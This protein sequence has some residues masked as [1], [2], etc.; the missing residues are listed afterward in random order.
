MGRCGW[1][2]VHTCLRLLFSSAFLSLSLPILRR[3]FFSYSA[4]LI[5][6][7]PRATLFFSPPS[8]LRWWRCLARVCVCVPLC[9]PPPP[10]RVASH[11]SRS[12]HLL[13]PLPLPPLLFNAYVHP[14]FPVAL[15]FFSPLPG[16][17]S[18][19]GVRPHVA[20]FLAASCQLV[21]AMCTCVTH[22][23]WNCVSPLSLRTN[24]GWSPTHPYNTYRCPY[25]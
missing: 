15:F 1:L 20:P 25:P 4:T 16:A 19:G 8:H 6:G 12:P 23:G 11:T 7:R 2:C 21:D 17:V 24:H 18:S 22:N 3:I 14:L 13:P 10:P 5:T 9:A